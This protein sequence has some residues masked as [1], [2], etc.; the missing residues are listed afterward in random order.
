MYYQEQFYLKLK[1]VAIHHLS[2][3]TERP[4]SIVVYSITESEGNLVEFLDSENVS[5]FVRKEN[6]KL[7]DQEIKA[8]ILLTNGHKFHYGKGNFLLDQNNKRFEGFFSDYPNGA[9][10]G[11]YETHDSKCK[12]VTYDEYFYLIS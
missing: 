5:N 2:L 11:F 4:Q 7:T 9:Q 10:L 8:T 1:P 12:L 6:G 3:L